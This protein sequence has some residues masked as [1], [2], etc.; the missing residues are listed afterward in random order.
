MGYVD[1]FIRILL[2]SKELNEFEKIRMFMDEDF[3]SND[4][5][6]VSFHVSIHLRT[7]ICRFLEN[8][9][10]IFIIYKLIVLLPIRL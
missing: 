1:E 6:T 8:F 10:Y 5:F 2:S 7:R 4:K 3:K 9:I